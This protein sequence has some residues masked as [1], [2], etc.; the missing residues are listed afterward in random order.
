MTDIDI[1]KC[2]GDGACVMYCPEKAIKLV[3]KKAKVDKNKCI[4]CA[5]CVSSCNYDAIKIKWDDPM[6]LLQEKIVEFAYAVLKEKEGKT[7]FMNY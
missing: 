5:E 4:G 1:K 2:V 3:N 7:G 6:D